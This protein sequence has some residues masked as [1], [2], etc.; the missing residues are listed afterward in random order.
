MGNVGLLSEFAPILTLICDDMH[1]I[2]YII[3]IVG[4]LSEFA[5]LLTMICDDKDDRGDGKVIG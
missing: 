3:F 5:R 2:C 1:N 4:P